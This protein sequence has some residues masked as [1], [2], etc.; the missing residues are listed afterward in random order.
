[1][2]LL[3]FSIVTAFCIRHLVARES[4]ERETLGQLTVTL[5]CRG[6]SEDVTLRRAGTRW[7]AHKGRTSGVPLSASERMCM[8]RSPPI[9]PRFPLT[10]AEWLN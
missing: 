4:G 10:V 3:F 8:E 9:L 1:M 7:S 6:V 2:L 5:C